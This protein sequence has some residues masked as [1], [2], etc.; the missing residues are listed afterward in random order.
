M[1]FKSQTGIDDNETL[2]RHIVAVQKK[3]YEA[4][5]HQNYSSTQTYTF[6]RSIVMAVY[7]HLTLPSNPIY[8]LH[9]ANDSTFR[10]KIA[11]MPVYP[12]VLELCRVRQDAIL[13]DVG[14]CCEA[15]LNRSCSSWERYEEGGS[16][17]LARP[18]PERR[19]L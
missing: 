6:N 8:R 1:F 10:M 14:C 4:C 2:K 15:C 9:R 5:K 11:R 18:W 16:R 12:S 17:R 7:G 13:F 19:R 3:A